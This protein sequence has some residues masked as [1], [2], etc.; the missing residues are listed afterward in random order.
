M[1]Y[2]ISSFSLI[3]ALVFQ[4]SFDLKAQDLQKIPF[5]DYWNFHGQS[6]TGMPIDEMVTLP[7]SWN[8]TDA[9]EGILYYRGKGT[10]VKNFDVEKAWENH[11][12][13]IRFEGVNI[14]ALVTINNQELGEHKGGYAAF[15]Y[16]CCG[17]RFRIS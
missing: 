16:H 11:R 6:V 15:C 1:K 3:L 14:T 10:Y 7:H 17:Q 4:I 5:N 8:Q 13:F 9:Q 2:K 12:I